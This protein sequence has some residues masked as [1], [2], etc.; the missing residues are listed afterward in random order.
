M[1][2]NTWTAIVAT[3]QSN[4]DLFQAISLAILGVG[5]LLN[6]ISLVQLPAAF[7]RAAQALESRRHRIRLGHADIRCRN[8]GEHPGAGL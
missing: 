5:L 6:A 3:L 4:Q 7:Q 2:E 1:L 8:P